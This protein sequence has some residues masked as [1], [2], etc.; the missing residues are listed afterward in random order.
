M[1]KMRV[2]SLAAVVV[3]ATVLAACGGQGGGA[4][5]LSV[6]MTDFAFNP[7]TYTVPAGAEVTLNLVNSGS[8]EH[9]FVIMKAGYQVTLPFDADDEPQVFWEG[10]VE[11][12][13]TATYVFTAPTEP[14]EYQVVCGVQGHLESGM[15]ATLTVTQ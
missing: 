2:V 1:T 15:Q 9:E 14:G 6:D 10:E 13:G 12:A 8:V 3:L 11:A 5:N 4:T 7:D